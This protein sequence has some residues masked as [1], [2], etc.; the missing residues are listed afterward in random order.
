MKKIGII[1]LLLTCVSIVLY[2][3]LP[4]PENGETYSHA[5]SIAILTPTSHPA[6][7]EIERGF[8]ETIEKSGLQSYQFTTF[9]AHGDR[10]LL[11][12]QAEEITS[13]KYQAIFTLGALC[14]QTVAELLHKKNSTIPHIFG[15]VDG[16]D[17]AQSLVTT[18]QSSTGVYLEPDYKQSMDI[19]FTIKPDTQ[20]ILLVY[21][22]TQGTGLEKYKDEIREYLRTYQATLESI[23]I[24]SV[25]EIQQKVSAALTNIDVVL[26]LI[27]N[28]VVSGI[29]TLI[30]LCNRYGI[31][32]MVSD[33]PSGEKGAA[34][35]YAVAEYETG[36]QAAQKALAILDDYALPNSIPVSA[37][38]NFKIAI[39]TATADA[40][41]I[42]YDPEVV[43]RY[44]NSATH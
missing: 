32:L 21:D 40:Q 26:V 31:T 16:Y 37:V 10:S 14:S 7:E 2:Y 43:A 9:N 13:G 12:A 8:K 22:P 39:N 35:A 3:G 34:I 23:E 38:S 5:I 4:Q 24:Y 44:T 36:S 33:L 11:R 15:G 28:T 1:F 25:N 20:R 30:T 18:N 27:D 29:D 42:T 17:F 6:L 19:L 41:H